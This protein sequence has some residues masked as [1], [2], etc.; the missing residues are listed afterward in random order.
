[1]KDVTLIHLVSEQTMQNLLPIMAL[2]PRRVVQVL[3]RDDRFPAVA[4]DLELAVAAL[5]RQV[6]FADLRPQFERVQIPS[7]SPTIDEATASLHAIADRYPDCVI[8][9]TGGTKLMSIGARQVAVGRDKPALYCDTQARRL[10]GTPHQQLSGL[11]PFDQLV[12]ALTVEAVMMA[13][14]ATGPLRES[15]LT[16]ERCAFGRQAYALRSANATEFDAY[17]ADLERHFYAG[18]RRMPWARLHLQHLASDPLP[19]PPSAATASYLTAGADAGF[20]LSLPGGG[21]RP[22]CG[23]DLPDLERLATILIGGWL[24]LYVAD[25]MTANADRFTDVHWSVE[26]PDTALGETDVV[27]VDKARAALHLVSCKSTLFSARPLEHLEALSQRRRDM[28]GAFARA[29][30]AV[31]CGPDRQIAQAKRWGKL[32]G[33]DVVSG[34]GIA[35]ALGPRP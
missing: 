10:V 8:N 28:G 9:F 5:G 30:L 12:A 17:R 4:G 22:N 24:E 2:R 35:A 11:L 15:L 16:P 31:F 18:E 3:S 29:T 21:Y 26:A 19:Q 23:P 6:L 13:H 14:G 32:L 34:N 27:A 20:L 25:L 1:M 7:S 33:V